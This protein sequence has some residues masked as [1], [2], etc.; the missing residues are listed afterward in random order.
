M[1]NPAHARWGSQAGSAAE[2]AAN[3]IIALRRAQGCWGTAHGNGARH[4]APF[5]PQHQH[6]GL[7]F[8]WVRQDKI[9]V[10]VFSLLLLLFFR[11]IHLWGGLSPSLKTRIYLGAPFEKLTTRSLLGLFQGDNKMQRFILPVGILVL[12]GTHCQHHTQQTSDQVL[13]T[14]A[15]LKCGPQTSEAPHACFRCTVA[16]QK[17]TGPPLSVLYIYPW[18]DTQ[19][20]RGLLCALAHKVLTKLSRG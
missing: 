3:L 16:L 5:S 18:A 13:H 6:L 7:L 12:N 4:I 10:R 8:V 9:P 17:S 20:I 19:M 11:V 14:T 1:Q 15:S 2:Q